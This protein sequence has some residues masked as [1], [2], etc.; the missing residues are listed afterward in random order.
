MAIKDGSAPFCLVSNVDLT[1]EPE[2]LQHIVSTAM[3][4]DDKVAAWELRQKPYEHPK[5]YDPVTGITN[6]NSHA[7]VLFRRS[8]I[9]KA[10]CYDET[11]FMY[12]EDVELS[13]RLR[14]SGALLRYCPHAVVN[15]YT[16]EQADQIK[17]I[18][19]SGSTFS[20]FYLRLK[21]GN[22]KDIRTI[23]YL[24]RQL[25]SEPEPY[26]GARRAIIRNLIRLSLLTPKALAGRRRTMDN[27]FFPF[28]TWDYELAREGAFVKHRELPKDSPLVSIITRTYKGRELYLRQALL[29]VA[30]QS[31]Q[32]I[33]H[34]VVEDGGVSL[35]AVVEQIGQ[36][37]GRP[38]M[39]INNA[40]LGRSAAGNVGLENARGRW[41]LF[42][43]DDDL[44]FAEHVEVL[45]SALTEHSDAVAAYSLAWEVQT[46]DSCIADGTYIE[47]QYSVPSVLTEEYDYKTLEHH[48]F[49]AIQSVLFERRLFEE[50]G[51]FVPDLDVLEDWVLWLCYGYGN[52]FI[53]VPK[54][55]SMFR[56]PSGQT[57]RDNRQNVI[58]SGYETALERARSRIGALGLKKA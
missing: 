46:D 32:N 34:I 49:M 10:G 21:Y 6:W 54:V 20:N 23:P 40:K 19:Y 48:N 5:F 45:V 44:L 14:R 1:F 28:Y 15:H 25:L 30:H 29:S 56:T 58:D 2:A 36:L 39:Y 22:F 4:D 35:Q 37:T 16:Y 11:L 57:V 9:E 8:S 50:R 3:A 26:P 33:E 38:A 12:G 41:C 18:Q 47:E 52:Q 55:T 7:C 53:Y 43:D 31:Y 13:Y 42:L 17:P 24:A 27:V 51:G